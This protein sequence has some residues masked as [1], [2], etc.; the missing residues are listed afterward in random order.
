MSRK[1]FGQQF[2]THRDFG[3]QFPSEHDFSQQFPANEPVNTLPANNPPQDLFPVFQFD[4][5][6]QGTPPEVLFPPVNN[7][8]TNYPPHY[9][10]PTNDPPH[11]NPPTNYYP[12]H[13]I[14]PPANYDPPQYEQDIQLRAEADR[15]DR[16]E[17]LRGKRARRNARC[18]WRIRFG[19]PHVSTSDDDSTASSQEGY[20]SDDSF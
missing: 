18:A 19:L 4:N 11:Y 6:P 3:Q 12:P 17:Y 5:P 15:R 8:P 16:E 13:Y 1:D 7:P 20:V 14:N 9:N 10:P 2:P